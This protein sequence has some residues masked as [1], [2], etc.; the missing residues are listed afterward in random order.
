MKG[1]LYI[2]GIDAYDAYGISFSDISYDDLV[3]LPEMKPVAFNDWHEKNG[4]DPDL[5][6]PVIAAKDVIL[7]FYVSDSTS[8]YSA[9]LDALSDG[10][11]HNFNFKEIGLSKRLRLKKSSNLKSILGLGSFSLTFSDDDPSDGLVYENPSSDIAKLGDYLLDSV[12]FAHYGIRMLNGTLDSILQRAEVKE[13]LKRN[14]SVI[15]GVIY[16][17]SEVR[18]KSRT[19]QLRCFMRASSASEF[20][21]NRNA[22]LHDLTK[23]GE[24]TLTVS[25]IG[26]QIPCYYKKC[27][28]KCFFPD[29]G[30]FWFEFT[31]SLEFFK[32]VI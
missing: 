15:S 26:K 8:S 6:A 18:Y 30:K 21:R 17:D 14:I 31:L 3:C 1:I 7:N 27:D 11:Y 5:S 12:D 19:A 20:W 10:S 32:G 9:F 25:M 22:L 4:I 2:D 29:R 13:N 23:V 16:D 24:R 28:V